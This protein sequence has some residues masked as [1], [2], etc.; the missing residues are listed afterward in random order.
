M[1]DCQLTPQAHSPSSEIVSVS[2]SLTVFEHSFP[3]PLQD[4]GAGPAGAELT[5]SPDRLEFSIVR[6]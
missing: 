5:D 1:S 6:V 3:Q 2:F 4:P